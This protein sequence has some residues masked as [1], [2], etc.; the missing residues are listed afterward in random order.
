MINERIG[1]FD[2]MIVKF[3]YGLN[4]TEFYVF[5]STAKTSISK[6]QNS[7]NEFELELFKHI[8]TLIIE[9]QELKISPRDALNLQ[10]KV[11]GKVSKVRTEKL[12]D[13][14]TAGGYF[15]RHDNVIFLGPKSLIEFKE[16]LQKMNAVYLRSCMLCEDVAAWVRNFSLEFFLLYFITEIS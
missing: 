7:Y 5:Y 14:W 15:F 1:R 2:Q 16:N 3:Q 13:L 6:L 8:F 11:A 4:L 10:S 9:N 12:I